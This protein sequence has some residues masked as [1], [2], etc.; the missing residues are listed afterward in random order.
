MNI[1]DRGTADVGWIKKP[2]LNALQEPRR[3]DIW[4]VQ[5]YQK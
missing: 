3:G 2:T 1:S 5:R 4:V